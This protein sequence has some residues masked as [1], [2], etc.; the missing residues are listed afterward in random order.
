ML[1]Y[2]K[3]LFDRTLGLFQQ[4]LPKLFSP[5]SACCTYCHSPIRNRHVS[6]KGICESC[7]QTIPWIHKVVCSVCGRYEACMDCSRR[8]ESH[9]VVN[10]SAVEYSDEMREWLARYKYRGDESLLPLLVEM[11]RY[12]Y[13]V[14]KRELPKPIDKFDCITYIPLSSERIAERGFNQ[15]EQLAI[16]IGK[17][18]DILVLPLLKRVIHT[19]KQSYKT[20]EQ[21]LNDLQ[22]AFTYHRVGHAHSL[23]DQVGEKPLHI[24]LIDDV[25]TTGSTLNQCASVIREHLN[26]RIYGLTWA[27]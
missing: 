6:L 25:Y 12:P 9:Y 3:E 19:G 21:R 22:H 4:Y 24:L 17:A 11:L 26:A 2:H 13:E 23:L 16:E 27:R 7:A 5:S 18:Y 1:K 20:R 14:L 10:R 8:K 15:A